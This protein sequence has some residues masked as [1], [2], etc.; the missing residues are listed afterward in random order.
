MHNNST[1]C[2]QPMKRQ[3]DLVEVWKAVGVLAEPLVLSPEPISCSYF[4]EL[5]QV[6]HIQGTAGDKQR[7][8]MKYAWKYIKNESASVYVSVF[9]G[10]CVH[11][12]S[13]TAPG[14][15]SECVYT[16]CGICARRGGSPSS[17]TSRSGSRPCPSGSRR[18]ACNR[19]A[20]PPGRS[21]AAPSGLSAQ[22]EGEQTT[23][24]DHF[25]SGDTSCH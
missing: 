1:K 15:K 4:P 18:T 17:P 14:Y 21:H 11:T 20:L 13:D 7:Q 6:D 12:T 19:T 16:W 10:D 2:G 3:T 5:L 23:Q 25:D 22:S 8:H 9:E 24:M